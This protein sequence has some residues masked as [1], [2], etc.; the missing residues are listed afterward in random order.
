MK[1]DA[2]VMF[3]TNACSSWY[4]QQWKIAVSLLRSHDPIVKETQV[5]NYGGT[6]EE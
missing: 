4:S 3:V 5:I 6:R 1:C 2:K